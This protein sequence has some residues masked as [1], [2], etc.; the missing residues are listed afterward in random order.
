MP[1]RREDLEAYFR[2]RA[3][4]RKLSKP[5]KV[6]MAH[7]NDVQDP[8][9][10]LAVIVFQDMQCFSMHLRHNN[11]SCNIMPGISLSDGLW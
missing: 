11:A 8:C 2:A 9:E 3:A 4:A 10:Q 5:G 7:N 6:R 1:E